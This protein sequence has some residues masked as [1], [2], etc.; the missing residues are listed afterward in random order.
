MLAV[1]SDAIVKP[2][3]EPEPVHPTVARLDDQLGWYEKSA[4]RSQKSYRGLKLVALLIGAAIP[5]AAALGASAAVA[6]VLGGLVV[7]L[8]GV[9][10]LFHYQENWLRYRG[11]A[12]ALRTEKHLFEAHAGSYATATDRLQLLAERIEAM[13]AQ[14][15]SAWTADQSR[16]LQHHTDSS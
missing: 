6:G 9:Q 16:S 13:F 8:E 4:Q 10:Q 2:D 3:A 15:R 5:V 14:E 1:V 12:E 11:M 7:V